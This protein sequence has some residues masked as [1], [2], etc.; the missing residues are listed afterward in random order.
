MLLGEDESSLRLRRKFE[1]DNGFDALEVTAVWGS[2]ARSPNCLLAML[3]AAYNALQRNKLQVLNAQVEAGEKGIELNVHGEQSKGGEMLQDTDKSCNV[4]RRVFTRVFMHKK[5]AQWL[6]KDINSAAATACVSVPDVLD[7]FCVVGKK[8][9]TDDVATH[10]DSIPKLCALYQMIVNKGFNWCIDPF[11]LSDSTVVKGG[12][13]GAINVTP[14][15]GSR[16][17]QVGIEFKSSNGKASWALTDISTRGFSLLNQHVVL[18]VLLLMRACTNVYQVLEQIF[19]GDWR[20]VFFPRWVLVESEAFE[21]IRRVEQEAAVE[22]RDRMVAA[23]TPGTPIKLQHFR[24]GRK[25]LSCFMN[26]PPALR[27]SSACGQAKESLFQINGGSAAV[28]AWAVQRGVNA[29]SATMMD[30]VARCAQ[31]DNPG[32]TMHKRFLD[33]VSIPINIIFM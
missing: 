5:M 17:V 28:S 8:L 16:A 29:E 14:R 22:A 6:V 13:D 19:E 21:T 24:E 33:V 2:D 3:V 18:M 23:G 31:L 25:I 9:W 4:L 1:A 11:V 27:H 12:A 32:S 30:V 20:A 26:G 7:A 15:D 10:T